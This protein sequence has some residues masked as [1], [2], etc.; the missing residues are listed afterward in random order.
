MY[1]G[2]GSREAGLVCVF[3][4]ITASMYLYH[5]GERLVVSIFAI[6]HEFACY[7]VCTSV[8]LIRACLCVYM[9]K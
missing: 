2:G 9:A 3:L 6:A 1:V 7:T 8:S 5:D 4:C